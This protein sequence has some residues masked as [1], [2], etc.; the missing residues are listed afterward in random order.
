MA[1]SEIR[2]TSRGN[3]FNSE[4]G[5]LSLIAP[6]T[7][8]SDAPFSSS[9]E[10]TFSADP[11]RDQHHHQQHPH[12]LFSCI[13]GPPWIV[14]ILLS[15]LCERFSFYALRAILVLFFKERLGWS[16]DSAVSIFFFSSALSYFMPLFGGYVADSK[17]GRFKTILG[18]SS[19]YVVG[20]F[21]LAL[22]AATSPEPYFING[23]EISNTTSAATESHNERTASEQAGAGGEMKTETDTTGSAVLAIFALCLIAVGTGGIK[24]NVSSFGADQFTGPTRAE[25]IGKFFSIFYFCI[26][27]GSVISFIVSPLLRVYAG[28]GIAFALPTVLLTVATFVFWLA[29]DQYV[30][31]PVGKS[32][33]A[34]LWNVLMAARKGEHNTGGAGSSS[35]SPAAPQS[36]D[37]SRASHWLNKARGPCSEQDVH[38]TID[39]WRQ[40]A[41]LLTLP[42]FWTLYDQQGSAWTLQAETMD[43]H[44]FLQPEQLGVVNPI[45]ILCLIPMFEK[46]I[47]P[48]YQGSRLGDRYPATSLFKIGVGML[49]ASLA[50]LISALVQSSIDSSPAN[51]V[52]VFAQLPQ[53]LVISISE[54]LVSITALEWVYETGPPAMKSTCASLFL[55][56]TAV[57]DVLGGVL[58][59]ILGPIMSGAGLFLLCAALMLCN[60]MLFAWVSKGYVY[61]TS[62]SGGDGSAAARE[63]QLE[64]YEAPVVEFPV[65]GSST[66]KENDCVADS[67]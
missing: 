32:P 45:L 2:R 61:P 58:Y 23:T 15:E 1:A 47:Y 39:V 17:L 10:G 38:D 40:G 12:K 6:S 31:K 3:S 54:I 66:E 33:V 8:S 34:V 41:I 50:F 64:A 26:N 16:R 28:Y 56:T 9:D 7:S 21:V 48:A 44:G 25:D 13:P 20:S 60:T 43:L 35:S 46:Y 42:I 63:E 11:N 22:A 59:S 5:Y 29:R 51:S 62:T 65:A 14:N 4:V 49:F 36:S 24:P 19:I 37:A 52:S 67:L 30:R 57:G 27:T 18:F 53:I 55:C